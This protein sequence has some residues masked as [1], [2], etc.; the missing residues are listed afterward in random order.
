MREVRTPRGS[1]F[2][3]CRRSE[4]EARYVKYPPQPTV[5]C[6]GYAARPPER[7]KSPGEG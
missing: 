1:R 5:R 2:L 7:A 3:Y 6:P 4:V